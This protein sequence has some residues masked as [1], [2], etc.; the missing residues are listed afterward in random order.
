MIYR[1]ILNYD[2]SLFK[3]II[4]IIKNILQQNKDEL[5]SYQQ[6]TQSL[7]ATLT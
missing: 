2:H 4:F 1:Y 3:G 6:Y 7:T 5:L